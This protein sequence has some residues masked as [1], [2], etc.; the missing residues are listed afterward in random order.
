MKAMILAAGRGERLRPLTDSTPKPLLKVNGKHLI[1]YHLNHLAQA[2][3]EEVIINVAWL[4]QQIIDVLGDG[5]KYQ[6]RLIY[7][8]EHNQVL[9]TGGGIF[10]ALPLLGERP[11]LVVNADVWTSYPFAQLYNFTLK[12]KAHL[13]LVENPKH[14]KQGDFGLRNGRLI[15][16]DQTLLT[17]S[18]IG[19][20]SA[21]FFAG[22][23]AGKFPLAPMLREYI[24]EGKITGERFEGDWQDIGTPQR[25]NDLDV[26]LRGGQ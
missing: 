6:L 5:K 10:N 26:M 20:Y 1:E 23:Q 16:S 12:D 19:V 13:V 4:G 7:S 11:F 22:V 15:E 3:F 2:G 14:H 9:E 17:Y 18:G 24:A 25:L 8:N 21:E